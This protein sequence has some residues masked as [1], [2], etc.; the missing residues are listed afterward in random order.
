MIDRELSGLRASRIGFLFQQFFLAEYQK[1]LGNVADRLLYAGVARSR[2]RQL[3]ADALAGQ[4]WSTGA[5]HSR[6]SSRRQPR[7]SHRREM[8]RFHAEPKDPVP[9]RAD[10]SRHHANPEVLM[11]RRPAH[12]RRLI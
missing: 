10:A 2:R 6:L 11:T 1:V 3:A 7:G 9:T 4:G 12:D 5:A 8:R